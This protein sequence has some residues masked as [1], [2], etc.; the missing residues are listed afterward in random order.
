MNGGIVFSLYLLEWLLQYVTF[1]LFE[2]FYMTIF[3]NYWINESILLSTRFL[4]SL[5]FP[6]LNVL[7]LT[8]FSKNT[9]LFWCCFYSKKSSVS[10]TTFANSNDLSSFSRILDS[11]CECFWK[12]FRLNCPILGKPLY[13]KSPYYKIIGYN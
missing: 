11:E 9:F 12:C 3:S 1:S 13:I 2:L 4:F 8:K 6:N 7:V 10:K 5:R